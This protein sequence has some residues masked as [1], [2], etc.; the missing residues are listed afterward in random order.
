M[1]RSG[2]QIPSG[3]SFLE[4]ILK[5]MISKYYITPTGKIHYLLHNG[6]GEPIVCIHGVGSNHTVWKHIIKNNTHPIILIDLPGHGKSSNP[7]TNINQTTDYIREILQTEKIQNPI[8]IGNSLGCSLGVHLSNQ[9]KISKL[10]LISPFF[11]DTVYS[12]QLLY[13]FFSTASHIKITSRTHRFIDYSTAMNKSSI[14]Y[15]F[16]DLEGTTL[17]T[18]MK[19]AAACLTIKLNSLKHHI[20]TLILYGTRD[21]LLK[22]DQIQTLA[23]HAH[24]TPIKCDHLLLYHQSNTVR[25]AINT[26]LKTTI[27]TTSS[28]TQ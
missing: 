26:F 11:Y 6:R 22:K 4:T 2:V 17:S 5:T 7:W 8:I 24:I 28:H 20:P 14:L 18:W 21:I 16:L 19:T 3:S 27:T 23:P 10:T 1:L 25:T 15:P 9:I 12:A 13:S